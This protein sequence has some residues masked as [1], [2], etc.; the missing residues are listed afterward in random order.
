MVEKKTWIT[1]WFFFF[2]SFIHS[3]NINWVPSCQ[4]FSYALGIHCRQIKAFFAFIEHIQWA[5]KIFNKNHQCYEYTRKRKER[6]YRK[7][8]NLWQH[9]T[10]EDLKFREAFSEE[11]T[12]DLRSY[13][14]YR[15][16]YIKRIRAK[17]ELSEID[18]LVWRPCSRKQEGRIGNLKE[19]PMAMGKIARGRVWSEL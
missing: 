5:R 15:V 2:W 19:D 12:V 18:L 1:K 17:R 11:G 8:V 6:F 14:W 7:N 10:N 3:T 4:E 13:A 9:I 16:N